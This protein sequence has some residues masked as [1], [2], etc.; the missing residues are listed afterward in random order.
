MANVLSLALKVTADASGLKLDPVQR[1]LTRLGDEADKL[2]SQ[3]DKF[4]SGS[5]AAAAAQADFAKRAEE[6]ANTLREGGPGA[7]TQYAIAFEKLQGEARDLAAAFDEGIRVTERYRTEE[8]KQAIAV[9]K[10]NQLFAKGAI[11][12]ETY[13][14]AVAE[15][16]G[17]N[18]AAARAAAE[19]AQQQAEAARVQ[20]DALRQRQALEARAA[21]IINANLTAQERYE[22][23]LREL[24]DLQRQGLLTQ[25]QYNRAVAAARKPLDDAA[26][27]AE[28][29]A[30]AG[31][32]SS[33]RFNELSGIF[34]VLPGPLG[35]I[36]GR[37]SGISSASEGLSRIFAGGL[38]S[39][40]SNLVGS[41][42]ALV[43][44]VTLGLAGITAFAAGAAAV[45]RGLIQ[46]E[47]RVENLGN[48]AAKLG[49]SFEFIQ[50]LEESARRSGTSIDA[51]SAAFG[52]L[53]KSVLGVDEESKAAQKALAEIGITAA[54]LQSLSPEDQYQRIGRA[55]ADI[56]DPARRT[57]T[58]V[59]LF[60]KS[61]TDLIPFFNNLPGAAADIERFGR[62]LSDLDR[63]RID[64]FGGALDQLAV[65]SQGLGQSLLVP[66]TGLGEGITRALAEVTAGI[67]S[68][69]D[70]IGRILEPL[71]TNIGRV[72]ELIGTSL[73]NLGRVIGAVFEPFAVIAQEV[74]VALEPL[75]EGVFN[76]L[77]GISNAAVTT[78]EW[79]V[80]F[81]PIGAIAANVGALGETIGRVVTIITTA[82]SRIGEAITSVVS[83]F[84]SF[85]AQSPLLQRVGETIS[86]IF[87]TISGVFSRIAEAVGGFVGRLLT[88]AENFLGIDRSASAAAESAATLGDEIEAL[89]EEERKQATEREKFLQGFRDNVSKAIDESAKFGQAGFDA[90]LQYQTA[91]DELQRQFDAGILNEEAFKRAAEQADAAY[92]QQIETVKQT[93]TEI[94]RKAKAE[95]EAAQRAADAALKAAQQQSESDKKRIDSL[96]GASDA[97]NRAAQDIAAIEREIQRVQADINAAG[98]GESPALQ[99]RL[100]QLEDLQQAIGQGFEQGFDKAFE[101]TAKGFDSVIDKASE[102]GQAGIEA[103]ARLQDGIAKAQQQARDGILNREAYEQEVARQQELFDKELANIKALADE[104]RRV[105]EF[106]D[107]QIELARFGGDQQRLQ[108]SRNAAAIEAEI[109]RV[110]AEVNAA[111]AA[112]EQEAVRAGIERLAQLDQAAAKERDIASG[113]AQEREQQRRF[114]EEQAKQAQAQQQQ[115]LQQQSQIAQE[116]QRV[117]QEQAQ[118]AAAETERQIKRIRS[119][120]SIGQQSIG[121]ADLRTTEGASQFIQA[122]AGALDPNLAQQRAQTKLLQKIAANSGALQYLERGIGQSVRILGGVP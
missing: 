2:T 88:L 82:F 106:V 49:V 30:E 113:K 79:L 100:S 18:A 34:A 70:P 28:R 54:E 46:L 114:L 119:L 22:Q 35:N 6:L 45:A 38:Q 112:G 25:D 90:A 14:R 72:V 73:G 87:G 76:F 62:V 27:A 104:R 120:N 16:S 67:T 1:A 20:A 111:R 56:E 98:A 19:A 48:I 97:A 103:A 23:S 41:F 116:Q 32:E 51:V 37:I 117:L 3:F 58:A 93:A 77:E 83:N 63:S 96:L 8:E 15:A 95:E 26:A 50:T 105:N 78:T 92:R 84:G 115:A 101:A 40:I 53:Q 57:A 43:N 69:V 31:R 47:D 121:G 61:G 10:L 68:I 60:G 118:A 86:S 122:A 74:S 71:L 59:A 13:N 102:F 64:A 17:A 5:G 66:F 65:A 7:A 52:R 55:I 75:Y 109:G 36:A 81:T 24:N 39:G 44:P 21:Q 33:L 12:Q 91:I 108:A 110:T 9:E 107:Q 89:T 4:A 42:T 94:E 99:A 80:S 11:E 29:A 85:L